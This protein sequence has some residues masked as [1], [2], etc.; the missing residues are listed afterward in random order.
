MPPLLWLCPA[1]AQEG[2]TQGAPA[3]G[4]HCNGRP[5]LQRRCGRRRSGE[6]RGRVLRLAGQGVRVRAGRLLPLRVH[7]AGSCV[8]RKVLAATG[9]A[10]AVVLL[11]RPGPVPAVLRGSGSGSEGSSGAQGPCPGPQGAV[12][13]GGWAPA[14]TGRYRVGQRRAGRLC[15]GKVHIRRVSWD[16]GPFHGGADRRGCRGQG[17]KDASQDQER[18]RAKGEGRCGGGGCVGGERRE[19]SSSRRRGAVRDRGGREQRRRSEGA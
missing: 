3:H 1:R 10:A 13:P 19:G 9:V 18:R 12:W 2:R 11:P 14:G 15:F 8:A 17:G 4:A 5:P 6:R 7:G 16:D